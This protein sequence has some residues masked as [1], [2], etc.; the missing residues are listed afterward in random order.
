[1]RAIFTAHISNNIT[2]ELCVW[3]R[4]IATATTLY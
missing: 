4:G 2:S 3:K 1:M